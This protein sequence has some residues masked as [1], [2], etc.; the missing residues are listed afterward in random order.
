MHGV[1][2]AASVRRWAQLPPLLAA[3][4]QMPLSAAQATH[5]A[6]AV[7]LLKVH[8][9]Y[10]AAFNACNLSSMNWVTSTAGHR[11]ESVSVW[12]TSRHVHQVLPVETICQKFACYTP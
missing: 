11:L 3:Q 2:L 1:Q 10:V 6:R 4:L 8:V 7:A 5:L 9:A 12:L